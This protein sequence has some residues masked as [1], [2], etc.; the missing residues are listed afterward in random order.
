MKTRVTLIS[1]AVAL[2]FSLVPSQAARAEGN[3]KRVKMKDLPPAVQKTVREQSKGATIRGLS[4]ETEDGKTIYE[5]EMRVKGHP[6]DVSIDADGN[7]IEVEEAVTL[8]SL[9]EAVQAGI[10]KGAAESRIT[11]IESIQK[12]GALVA[13]E[14]HTLA[15]KKRGEFKVGLDGQPI[16][17]KN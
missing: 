11:L 13:Y 7:V 6:K 4:Q 10:K 3:E 2:A 16:E 8:A 14:V 12:G 5:V 9:P 17:E 15:G 1:A